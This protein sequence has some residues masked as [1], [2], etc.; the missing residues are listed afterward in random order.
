MGS[1]GVSVAQL[2][3]L[4]LRAG[5]DALVWGRDPV[6]QL[7][8]VIAAWPVRPDVVVL[9]GDIADDGSVEAYGR[10]AEIL[11]G[12]G[13]RLV[14]VPGNHDDRSAMATVFGPVEPTTLAPVSDAWAIA[15]I[16]SVRPGAIAGA[17]PVD[18]LPE[19]EARLATEDRS[20]LGFVH[21]PVAPPCSYSECG[22]AGAASIS[23]L[24][25]RRLEILASGHLH[26]PFVQHTGPALMLGA[27]STCVSLRHGDGELHWSPTDGD[28]GGIAFELRDDGT[29]HHELVVVASE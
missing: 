2:S 8:R 28:V 20:V 16:D 9:S 10:V 11:D 4:H 22:L 15:T 23:A 14:A 1:R 26:E 17:A 13:D 7:R 21:H 12:W 18:A 25:E 27:P 24:A 3:D 29:A 6:R 5:A 19:L